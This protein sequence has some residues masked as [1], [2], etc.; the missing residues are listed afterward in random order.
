MQKLDGV[1][2]KTALA[3]QEPNLN[4]L[5]ALKKFSA[6]Y[7]FIIGIG[8]RRSYEG[9]NKLSHLCYHVVLCVGIDSIH[10]ISRCLS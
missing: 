2:R 8:T 1:R 4:L 9:K 7:T 10:H 3:G 5:I 6:S